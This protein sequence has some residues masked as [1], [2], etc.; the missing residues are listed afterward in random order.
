MEHHVVFKGSRKSYDAVYH[1]K[2]PAGFRWLHESFGTNWRL[3]E[4][5]SAIGRVQ[6]RKLPVGWKNA[7]A[8]RHVELML[9]QT[10]GLRVPLPPRHIE[11]AYYKYYALFVPTH[12]AQLNR[13]CILAE[14]TARDF[15][16]LQGVAARYT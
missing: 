8:C 3:T 9:R 5:Q 15:H 1:R 10:A 7:A 14:I 11:H 13:D 2:H 4:I 16:A 12:F 6:L